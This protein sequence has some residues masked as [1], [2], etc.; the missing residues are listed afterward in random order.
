M[1]RHEEK[2][3]CHVC[4]KLLSVAYITDHM[5]VH[6]Q[7]PNHVCELCNKGF[8][9][10]AYLRVHSV[11]HHGLVC[12]R[13]DSFLCK[14]CSVHCKTLAQLSGHMHTHAM[15]GNTGLGTCQICPLSDAAASVTTVLPSS[16]VPGMVPSQPW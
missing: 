15:S 3:P 13:A 11:K 5:K 14:L 7:G 9:T 6:N 10:A 8:A 1:V 4:G 2:V 12:P 16:G